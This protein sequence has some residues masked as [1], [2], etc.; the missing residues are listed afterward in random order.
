MPN[1]VLLILHKGLK[2]LS[3]Q[4]IISFKVIL[5]TIIGLSSA[6]AVAQHPYLWLDSTELTIMR[7]K[8]A[9]NTADW[10]ALQ[11]KCNAIAGIGSTPYAILYQNPITFTGSNARGYVFA[12]SHA[13]QVLWGGLGGIQWDTAIEQLGACYQA[14]GSSNPAASAAI[15][16]EAHYIITAMAQPLLTIVRQSD[17]VTR[18]GASV[19]ANGTDLPAG[20]QPQ[21]Y[22]VY[23]SY[24]AGDIVTISGATGCTNLNGTFEVQSYNGL[25]YYV[26]AIS[27]RPAPTLN[28][29]C[30]L[31]SMVPTAGGGFATRAL[32]PAIAKAY[33]WFYL[34]LSTSYPSDLRNLVAAMTAWATELQYIKWGHH[35]GGNY[36]AGDIWGATAAYVAFNSD[37]PSAI[38]TPAKNV[39]LQHFYGGSLTLAGVTTDF[40]EQ[41]AQYNNLWLGGGGNGEGLKAYGYDSIERVLQAEYAMFIYK[42]TSGGKYGADWRSS[43]SALTMLDDNLQYFMEFVT[44]GLL[45]LDGNEDVFEVGQMYAGV[46]KGSWFPTEP[47]Y[48]PLDQAVFMTTMAARMS[49]RYSSRFQSFYDAVSAAEK[50]AAGPPYGLVPAWTDGSLPYQSSPE[51]QSTFLWYNPNAQTVDWYARL[52]LMHRA[53]G[54]NYATTR[55]AWNDPNATLVRFQAS[56]TVGPAG[57]GHTQ[58]DSGAVTIQTGNNRLLVYGLEEAVRSADIISD[59]QWN[60]LASERA[61]YGN[62]KNSIW[63][64]GATASSTT[65]QGPTSAL[66]PPGL[67]NTV[68]S[69]PSSMS[70]AEDGRDFTYFEGTHLEANAAKDTVDHQYHQVAWTRQ[71]FFLRPKLAIVHDRTTALYP[72]DDRSMFWTFGREIAQVTSNVPAGMVRY[73]AS[74]NGVYRGAF[75]SVL[76]ESANV[77]VVDHDDMHFLYRAEV[78]PPVMNHTSDNWLAVFDAASTPGAVNQVTNLQATNADAVQFNDANATIVAFAYVDPHITPSQT[79]AWPVKGS[80][81]QYVA[82]LTP[83][84]GYGVTNQAGNLVISATG[85]Y[86]A[87]SAGILIYT[88]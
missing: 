36:A 41:F 17:G 63:W 64:C 27:G 34:G 12:P 25:T 82:G 79:L 18:Y 2:S 46:L 16:E 61:L 24:K 60:K 7:N 3:P 80:L 54:G 11:A 62:K 31:Y 77:T 67:D 39:L 30:T 29:N 58:F 43:P 26:E 65:N 49:S 4:R 56:P 10:Q 21:F 73:D 33:D 14:L 51:P 68:T 74:F 28:A 1:L 72:A 81:A 42:L 55:S 9:S 88:K 13:P 87:S 59:P 71:V 48:V 19:A 52:P 22:Q 69:F 5:L 20:A 70:L 78:R 47:V 37:Q 23:G 76:P 66:K 75:W 44:P 8:V 84:A 40:P 85:P 35:P 50:A 45:S 15:L 57:G 83:G 53:W 86:R 6:S 32:M 38:G